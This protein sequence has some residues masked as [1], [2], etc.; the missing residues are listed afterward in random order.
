MGFAAAWLLRATG[1]KKYRTDVEK[2]WKDFGLGYR[3]QDFSWDDKGA[4]FQV[5]MAELTA[6]ETSESAKKYRTA[7]E[8]FCNHIVRVQKKTP[9]G[10]VYIGQWGTLRTAGN[11]AFIC[12]QAAKIGINSQEYINFASKQMGYAL[13]DT[14]RSY[15]V[16]LGVNPPQRPHHRPR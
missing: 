3:P 4:G 5:L 15:V 1:D 11:V 7:A 14:G 16:G 6:N 2:H 10:L 8:T 9:K 12:L 13:G